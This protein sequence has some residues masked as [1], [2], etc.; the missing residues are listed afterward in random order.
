MINT[1]EKKK[2]FLEYPHIFLVF[3]F[4]NKDLEG[5]PDHYHKKNKYKK[6]S[7]IS[8]VY[9]YLFNNFQHILWYTI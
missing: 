3:G 5:Q 6:S 4:T 7:G 1:N 2:E 8:N 9:I